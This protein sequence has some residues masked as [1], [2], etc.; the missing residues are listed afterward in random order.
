MDYDSYFASHLT[1]MQMHT[2][3]LLSNNNWYFQQSKTDVDT[4]TR[5]F[6]VEKDELVSLIFQDKSS[7]FYKN[8]VNFKNNTGKSFGIDDPHKDEDIAQYYAGTDHVNADKDQVII[9][10]NEDS[11][12]GNVEEVSQAVLVNDTAS[13]SNNTTLEN[14]N[15]NNNRS[16]GSSADESNSN[17]IT[18]TLDTIANITHIAKPT[19]SRSNIQ[20]IACDSLSSCSDTSDDDYDDD[21]D[22]NDDHSQLKIK[23]RTSNQKYGL[24]AY[25]MRNIET[26]TANIVISETA[27]PDHLVVSNF[28]GEDAKFIWKY[29]NGMRKSNE[30]NNVKIDLEEWLKSVPPRPS[31][32][33]F[34]EAA[35][36]NFVNKTY[37]NEYK[38]VYQRVTKL[39]N[40]VMKTPLQQYHLGPYAST[41]TRLGH[42]DDLVNNLP[43]LPSFTTI[44]EPKYE[45]QNVDQ[46]TLNKLAMLAM[47]N[48][49]PVLATQAIIKNH[50]IEQKK[51]RAEKKEKAQEKK[52]S[53][54]QKEVVEQGKKT[55]SNEIK[56]QLRMG[57]NKAVSIC[58]HSSSN[59]PV[60]NGHSTS[61]ST[62]VENASVQALLMVS[63]A[64]ITS[65]QAELK[66]ILDA[67]SKV[68]LTY[69]Q[70]NVSM[71][72]VFEK[73]KSIIHVYQSPDYDSQTFGLFIEAT[74]F[75][76]Q[77]FL[78]VK[79]Y[80]S[81][82]ITVNIK[83][84]YLLQKK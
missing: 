46:A 58:Q 41:V 70:L 49:D 76:R 15:N 84:V 9:S 11:E 8:K 6:S 80:N 40:E 50:E 21:V 42:E 57:S 81:E 43:I 3:K 20:N 7:T 25:N 73:Q 62:V 34:E 45:S 17:N 82:I 83:H 64:K 63:E 61:N 60:N 75:K 5:P 36:V 33:K 10:S 79:M 48:N 71:E 44:A 1:N 22:D 26:Q 2:K 59:V 37:G 30:P 16:S 24:I 29:V 68:T 31:G 38:N 18:E 67:P 32:D 4:T 28:D 74:E 55:D 19:T 69:R 27:G 51:Q 66:E 23:S 78:K 39:N 52:T 13:S 14:Y 53:K 72:T 56:A 65:T 77:R 12:D 47:A 35:G 54:T